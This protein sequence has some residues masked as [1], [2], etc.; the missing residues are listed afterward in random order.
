MD[1][2]TDRSRQHDVILTL[3]TKTFVRNCRVSGK[4]ICV[5]SLAHFGA[6]SLTG[7]EE[8]ETEIEEERRVMEKAEEEEDEWLR[9]NGGRI[10]EYVS[11]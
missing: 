2:H 11:Y 6:N 8:I 1:R 3:E 7:S 5:T 10:E 4:L 9:R